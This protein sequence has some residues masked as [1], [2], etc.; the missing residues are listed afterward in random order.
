MSMQTIIYK[1]IDH[2]HSWA[3]AMT[4]V[5]GLNIHFLVRY[6]YVR[7][8][9]MVYSMSQSNFCRFGFTPKF[10]FFFPD[11][12]QHFQ[13]PVGFT[14]QP[15]EHCIRA[16]QG[17]SASTPAVEA[18]SSAWWYFEYYVFFWKWILLEKETFFFLAAMVISPISPARVMVRNHMRNHHF[19]W[20]ST[21][22]M[23]W[24][25]QNRGDDRPWDHGSHRCWQRISTDL[26]TCEL[27]EFTKWID[28]AWWKSRLH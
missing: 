10:L 13:S 6:P 28:F 17:C 25:V 12:S 20:W 2:V 8:L 15:T 27:L 9:T 24:L 19:K 18:K 22:E 5:D 1:G 23:T 14:Y 11:M 16:R 26:G 3:I 7:W 4:A 21:I